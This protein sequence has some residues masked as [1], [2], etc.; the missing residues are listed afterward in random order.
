MILDA[1]E[2]QKVLPHR[3]PFLLVDSIVE[4]EEGVR[5]VGLKDVTLK[6]PWFAGHFPGYPIM[7]GVLILEAMAQTG[8]VLVVRSLGQLGNR[9]LLFAAIQEAKFR[10]QVV[11]GDQ[12]RMELEVLNRRPNACKMRGRATVNGQIAAEAVILCTIADMPKPE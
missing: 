5:I 6:D 9:I 11:P 7:P 4:L 3:Y 1:N 12:L 2:I 8:G 10:R